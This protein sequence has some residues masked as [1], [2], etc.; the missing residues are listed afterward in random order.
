MGAF[1]KFLLVI[2]NSTK[3]NK[4]KMY[5]IGK[6]VLIK[7]IF[8]LIY[9]ELQQSRTIFCYHLIIIIINYQCPH[10]NNEIRNTINF[11][12]FFKLVIEIIILKK[13]DTQT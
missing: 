11:V 7:F 10:N 12:I 1:A 4:D 3:K 5:C 6:M 9:S 13:K 8:L 2:I